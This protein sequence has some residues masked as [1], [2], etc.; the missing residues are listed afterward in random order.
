MAYQ[1]IYTGAQIDEAVGEVASHAGGLAG[2]DS[3]GKVTADAAC[4]GVVTLTG[5]TTLTG[6]HEGRT[7]LIAAPA[8]I[9][10][11]LPSTL[12]EGTEVELIDSTG[13]GASIAGTLFV[14]GSGTAQSATLDEYGIAAA[15]LIGSVWYVSG[16]VS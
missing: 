16:G 6:A 1:S 2:L 3:S 4:S 7:L 9:G 14:S 10:I 13:Y 11:T 15:K 12:T 5:N 8:A